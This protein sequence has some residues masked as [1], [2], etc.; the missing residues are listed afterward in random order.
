MKAILFQLYKQQL[1]KLCESFI[2]GLLAYLWQL[3]SQGVSYGLAQI[4]IRFFIPKM[5]AHAYK[6][7]HA[8]MVALVESSTV[9]KKILVG[10]AVMLAGAPLSYFTYGIFDRGYHPAEYWYHHNYW[11]LFFLIRYQ[12]AQIVFL[13]GLYIA[14]P[15]NSIKKFI[16]PYLGFVLMGITMNVVAESNDD[17]WDIMNIT[18]WAAGIVLSLILFFLI[19]WLTWRKF[20]RVDAFEAREKGLYQIADDVTPEKFKSMVMETWRNKFEFQSKY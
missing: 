9:N 20:H 7:Q 16:A 14:L 8:G 15:Q 2:S 1:L 18:L 3:P 13:I 10:L 19:D 6:A 5:I 12:I 11:H 4:K 17:I